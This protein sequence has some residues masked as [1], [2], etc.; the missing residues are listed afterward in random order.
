MPRYEVRN[1]GAGPYASFHC[2]KCD[3][4]F[5]S[6]PDLGAT[7]TKSV[8]RSLV[9]GLLRRV[10]LLD[11]A[12]DRVL[13]E[14]S[15]ATRMTREQLEAAWRQVEQHF[16]DCPT[17]HLIVCPSDWDAQSGFCVDDSPRAEEITRAKTEQVA[18]VMKGIASAFGIDRAVQGMVRSAQQAQAQQPGQPAAPQAGPAAAA[19]APALKCA[20]CGAAVGDARFCPQ[21]GTKV[22][23]P[24]PSATAFCPNCGK[25][26]KGAKFCPECGTKVG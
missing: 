23:R 25:E 8:G 4:E 22:E 6:T 15:R 12:A 13:E 9:G 24:A 26:L 14:P 19:G 11:A 16:H 20:A 5:R 1:D 3:R 2:D 10:P 17:C 18:G 7:V 21:C